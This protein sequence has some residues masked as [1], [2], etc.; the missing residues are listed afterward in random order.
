MVLDRRRWSGSNYTRSSNVEEMI[1]EETKGLS[2]VYAEGAVFGDMWGYL[3]P[4]T[5]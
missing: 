2:T 1:D 4:E 5:R 3:P